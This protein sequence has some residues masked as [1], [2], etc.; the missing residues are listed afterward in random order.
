MRKKNPGSTLANE[1]QKNKMNLMKI[2]ALR[3]T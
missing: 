3:H 2:V 1:L